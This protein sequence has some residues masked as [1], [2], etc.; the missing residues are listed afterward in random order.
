MGRLESTLSELKWLAVGAAFVTGTPLWHLVLKQFFEP[1]IAPDDY[2]PLAE[3]FAATAP[4]TIGVAL[5]VVVLH[6]D[7]RFA[8]LVLA[9]AIL[10]LSIV[11]GNLF[12]ATAG[13]VPADVRWWS[14]WHP[15]AWMSILNQYLD[16]YRSRYGI[17]HFIMGIVIGI[18]MGY[19]LV[20]PAEG[21]AGTA[22]PE[23]AVDSTGGSPPIQTSRASPSPKPPPASPRPA[24]HS[25]R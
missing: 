20:Q 4:M 7:L 15:S 23:V 22:D 9:G 14:F 10:W 1:G 6:A 8:S 21:R 12:G 3:I 16:L 18:Y 24:K 5:V 2:V 17:G 13:D 19:K 25:Q 11:L